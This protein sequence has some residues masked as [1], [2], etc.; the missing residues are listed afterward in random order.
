V[1]RREQYEL[2]LPFFEAEEKRYASLTERAT[3][4]L[5]LISVISLFGGIKLAAEVSHF[6]AVATAVFV[7]LAVLSALASIFIRSYKGICDVE[8]MIFTI[9]DEQYEA[10]DVYSDLLANLAD[11]VPHNRRVNTTRATWLQYSAL[12][13]ALALI[14]AVVTALTTG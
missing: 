2:F 10:E 11:A 4:F 14:T 5:G 1:T 9:D 8:D 13:F 3:I 7:L 12:F 6:G